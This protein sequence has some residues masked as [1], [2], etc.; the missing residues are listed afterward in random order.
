MSCT[1]INSNSPEI[2]GSS[3]SFENGKDWVEAIA[4]NPCSCGALP[5]RKCFPCQA[6]EVLREAELAGMY[7]QYEL[8]AIQQGDK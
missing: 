8:R 7:R 1:P 2:P 5:I 6:K 4:D 3:K